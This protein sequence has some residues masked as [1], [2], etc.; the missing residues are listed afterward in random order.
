M[1]RYKNCCFFVVG[2]KQYGPFNLDQ[3][4]KWAGMEL[5]W[6]H[7]IYF[8][9]HSVASAVATLCPINPDDKTRVWWYFRGG[10][11]H[12]PFSIIQLSR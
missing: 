3:I 12:G 4:F 6:D 9:P 7:D 8:D 11:M 10:E 1:D 5:R 2:A